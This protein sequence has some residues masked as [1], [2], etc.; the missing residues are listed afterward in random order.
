M[1]RLVICEKRATATIIADIINAGI[2]KNGYYEGSDYLVTW[3]IG[4]HA[5]LA[6]PEKYDKKYTGKWNMRMLPIMPNV[7]K[8]ELNDFGAGQYD[9]IK[10]L[11]Y[12]E[13]V[14]YIIC[15]TDF[16]RE[17]EL[18]FRQLYATLGSGKQVKRLWLNSIE[19]Q[20]VVTAFQNL[21]DQEE[22]DNLYI[23]G[24]CRAKLDWLIGMNCTRL[25][26]I[27]SGVLHNIGRVQAIALKL[28]AKR[29]DEIISFTSKI[30]YS[31]KVKTDNLTLF[32][33]KFNNIEDAEALKQTILTVGLQ[34]SDVD[35]SMFTKNPPELF[36]LASLQAVA[37]KLYGYTAL[38][39]QDY[40]QSLYESQLITY[41]KTDNRYIK[42]DMTD[43]YKLSLQYAAD[44][45]GVSNSDFDIMRCVND[46]NTEH[47]AIIITPTAHHK[48]LN[49]L[50]GGEKNIFFLIASRMILAVSDVFSCQHIDIKLNCA[51]KVLTAEYDNV[52]DYGWKKIEYNLFSKLRNMN[53]SESKLN[54]KYLSFDNM[55]IGD[56]L[57]P[58]TVE[59]VENYS[60]PPNHYTDGT[61]IQ[62]LK[63]LE[64]DKLKGKG[65]G[66]PTTRANIIEKL[67]KQGY[68]ERINGKILITEKGINL[69]SIIPAPLLDTGLAADWE[70]DLQKIENGLMN[71]ETFML[72]AQSFI[73]KIVTESKRE[74]TRNVKEPLGMCPKCGG[75]VYEGKAAFYCNNSVGKN[76]NCSFFIK[77]DENF[78]VWKKKAVTAELVKALLKTGKIKMHNLYS[79]RSND[80][81]DGIVIMDTSKDYV[82]FSVKIIKSDRKG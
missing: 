27:Q 17:G 30:D 35:K 28:L 3:C 38:Q 70:V 5:V 77:K 1:K 36:D 16:S 10:K 9:I 26:T 65:I 80:Y 41:P 15:A 72:K 74:K 48:N 75:N 54:S 61:L 71:E 50:P 42:K 6:S 46:L 14:E 29:E 25:I 34:I 64:Y 12:S 43:T 51:D 68:A 53:Y 82:S 8:L 40:A 66:T 2:K 62:A 58:A 57:D 59:I 37:N 11:V 4:S 60:V 63:Y 21:N 23:A 7:W 19:P 31:V 13:Q 39:T 33:E 67:I 45:L 69:V 20:T 76:N 56:H 22:Y 49:D 18:I 55:Q 24:L 47:S 44:L 78:F 73:R 81:Y 32:S 79:D 52:F